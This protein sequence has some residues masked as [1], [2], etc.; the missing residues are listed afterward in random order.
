LIEG[1]VEVEGAGL[2]LL[3]DEM[4]SALD[5]ALDALETIDD[6]LERAE[7]IVDAIDQAI[8]FAEPYLP[9]GVLDSLLQAQEDLI[10]AK[11]AY[12]DA[13]ASGD[14]AA[15]DAAKDALEAA[16]DAL[17][18]AQKAYVEATTEFFKDFLE[19]VVAIVK[20]LLKDCVLGDKRTTYSQA[21]ITF[22]EEIT[23]LNDQVPLPPGANDANGEIL[24]NLLSDFGETDISDISIP[25]LDSVAS[26]FYQKEM[27]Y[28]LC[29]ALDK[30]SNELNDVDT[31]QKLNEQLRS[32]G[33][34]LIEE[35]GIRI[36]N[37][38]AVDTIVQNFKG[39]LLEYLEKLLRKV[40]YPE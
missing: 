17:K 23:I 1:F 3:S 18:D 38:Q 10:K 24:E 4:I 34:N 40:N 14:Q 33:L 29:V 6:V 21:Y 37:G 7:D 5:D 36:K 32:V 28:M 30:L 12:E 26:D 39:D 19:V 8:A 11:Q 15:I 2:K 20:D 22:D 25:E 31:A 16:K 9:D 27:D 35:I 13:Q